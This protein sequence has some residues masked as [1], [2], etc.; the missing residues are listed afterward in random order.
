[1]KRES[2][3]RQVT[4]KARRLERGRARR[5]RVWAGLG[6]VGSVGWIV[7]LPMVGGAFAGRWID[8]RMGTGLS[9]TLGLV[10]VGLA[11]GAYSVWRYFLR[12][13]V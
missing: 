12:E 2:F 11:C 1:M 5:T 8:R 13:P 9:F 6:L 4:D 7:A 3:R 10:L